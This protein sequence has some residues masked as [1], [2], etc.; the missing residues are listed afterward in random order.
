MYRCRLRL[1]LSSHELKVFF[2]GCRLCLHSHVI[3]RVTTSLNK[4]FP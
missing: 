2:I 3:K 1:G 4:Q